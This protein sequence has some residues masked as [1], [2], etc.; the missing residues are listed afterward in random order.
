MATRHTRPSALRQIP[1]PRAWP[2]LAM[3]PSGTRPVKPNQTTLGPGSGE[4][5]EGLEL[6]GVRRPSAG[7]VPCRACPD[8]A[9]PRVRRRHRS[10]SGC[11]CATPS[12]DGCGSRRPATSSVRWSAR[13][14]APTSPWRSARGST[15]THGSRM[16]TRH[17][18]GRP[19]R[20]S[21]SSWAV[22]ER[23]DPEAVRAALDEALPAGLD[24]LEVVEA[25]PGSLADRLEASDWVIAVPRVDPD[26][27][28]GGGRR[29]PRRGPRRGDPNVQDRTPD[30]RH[31]GGRPG[32]A[33]GR[34]G[35]RDAGRAGRRAGRRGGVCDNSNGRTAHHTG[36]TP[37]RHSV[38]AACGRGSRAAGATS[39]DAAGAGSAGTRSR[40]GG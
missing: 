36:C 27:S 11:G 26:D 8:A 28:P 37:R 15:R 38:R 10:C 17:R 31:P 3:L 24:V 4:P 32:H 2:P 19:A 6:A 16:R 12:G 35:E 30:V 18:R 20:P 5:L 9:Y 13:C 39:G 1:Y 7:R 34:P 23:V 22:N 33:R 14:A 21:T 25:G 29:L 40:G